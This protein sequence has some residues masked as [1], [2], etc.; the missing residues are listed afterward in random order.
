[1]QN[2]V[3]FDSGTYMMNSHP[4]CYDSMASK[5]EEQRCGMLI[6][7]LPDAEQKEIDILR[8]LEELGYS[9]EETGTYFYKEV[10]VEAKEKLQEIHTEE[11]YINLINEMG[12]NY[13]QFYFDI[14]RNGHD[15]GLKTFH[16]CINLSYQNR[17]QR[18]MNVNLAQKIGIENFNTDYK[19]EAILIANYMLSKESTNVKPAVKKIGARI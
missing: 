4:K 3:K 18:P 11:E 10:I 2:N 17:I 15:I 14:A 19:S 5:Y 7:P 6:G 12:N 13:S 1:M 8:V 9:P 16:N